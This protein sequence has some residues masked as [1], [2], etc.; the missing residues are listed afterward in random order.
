MVSDPL[1]LLN[2]MNMAEHMSTQKTV[3][4]CV[5]NNSSFLSTPV[6]RQCTATIIVMKMTTF[7]GLLLHSS[8]S[9]S[10]G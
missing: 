4:W 1:D 3:I 7:L 2:W 9:S 6:L 10:I 5:R 8:S